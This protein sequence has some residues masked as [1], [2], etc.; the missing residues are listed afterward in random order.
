MSTNRFDSAAAD[1]DKKD[2]RVQLAAAIAAGIATLPL[3]PAMEALEYG[4][5]TGLVGL[6]LAPQ[7]KSLTAADSSPG[8]LATLTD[9]IAAAGYANVYPLLLDLHGENCPR[10][11][12]LIFSAMTLHHLAEVG[13]IIEKLVTGIKTGGYIALAD[14]DSEDGSFHGDN[15]EGVMHHGFDRDELG[16]ILRRLG[17]RIIQAQTVHTVV[18]PNAAGVEQSYPVFLLTAKKELP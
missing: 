10:Q 11:F 6:T 16:D 3:H 1:W 7:L 4:C 14:L 8:M 18:K 2:Q 13:P 12:D 5:G 9:K 15:T 17:C